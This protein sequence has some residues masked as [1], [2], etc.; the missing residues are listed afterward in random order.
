MPIVYQRKYLPM[1]GRFYCVTNKEQHYLAKEFP[2]CEVEWCLSELAKHLDNN[3][4]VQP[5]T[6]NKAKALIRLWFSGAS[7]TR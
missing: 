4:D 1:K 5:V 2:G 7:A 3:P 6:G